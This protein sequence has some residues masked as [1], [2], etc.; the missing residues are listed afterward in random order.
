MERRNGQIRALNEPPLAPLTLLCSDRRRLTILKR[1]F[2]PSLNIRT[3]ASGEAVLPQLRHASNFVLAAVDINF[4]R[5]FG[6][7]LLASC[8]S[9]PHVAGIIVFGTPYAYEPSVAAIYRYPCNHIVYGYDADTLLQVI[10]QVWR[11]VL[12]DE[13][14]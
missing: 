13:G 8:A 4:I 5:D 3:A 14:R 9:S 1:R 2:S 10:E 7:R 6:F 11:N 12:R